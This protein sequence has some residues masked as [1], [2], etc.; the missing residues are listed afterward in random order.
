M[1]G[2]NMHPILESTCPVAICNILNLAEYGS[3]LAMLIKNA[4][5]TVTCITPLGPNGECDVSHLPQSSLFPI[6]LP[7]P[8]PLI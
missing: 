7:Q 3:H 1:E 5:S 2:L 4:D 6:V 8:N